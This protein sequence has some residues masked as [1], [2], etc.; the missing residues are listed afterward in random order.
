MARLSPRDIRAAHELLT[1]LLAVVQRGEL[2][3]DGPLGSQLRGH[4]QGAVAALDALEGSEPKDE[5]AR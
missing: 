2:D 5:T 4:L 3:A 1:E